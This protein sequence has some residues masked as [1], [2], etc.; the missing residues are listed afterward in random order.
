ML[1]ATS[2]LIDELDKV[3][4]EGLQLSYSM[5][6]LNSTKAIYKKH[7]KIYL[8]NMEDDFIF[9]ESTGYERDEFLTKFCDYFWN[10]EMVIN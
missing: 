3:Y 10:I 2:K 4:P 1:V 5:G 6:V 8:F 7:E 9:R